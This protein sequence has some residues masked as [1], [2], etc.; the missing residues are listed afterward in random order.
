MAVIASDGLS[1]LVGDGAGS[2]MFSPLQGVSVTRLELTQRSNISTAVGSDAW[3]VIA[4]AS[5]RR[6]LIE[7]DAYATDDNAAIRV[8]SLM[9]SGASGNFKIK[10]SGTQTLQ[11]SAVVTF[12]HERIEAGSIKKLQC[13]LE[14][15]AAASVV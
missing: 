7:A 6:L 3:Q 11:F 10:L 4:G 2:E 15:S 12:Y 5:G 13:R 9:F 8:R 1:L 14:S